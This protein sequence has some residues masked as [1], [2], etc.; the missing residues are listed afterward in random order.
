V[1]GQD[2]GG[3]AEREARAA[4]M[5]A[6]EPAT[7][8][9]LRLVHQAGAVAAL[10]HVL[11]GR[12]A[13][14]AEDVAGGGLD[15]EGMRLRIDS[16]SGRRDLE[17]AAT[18]GARLVIPTDPDWPAGLADLD[19][20]GL[21]CLGLYVRGRGSFVDRVEGA[22]AIVGTRAASD[23]GR[24]VAADLAHG[25]AI[26]GRATVSGLAFGIDAAA[27]QGALS[28]GVEQ[29]GTVAVLACG[30]DMV[31]PK[32]HSWLLS[33]VLDCGLVVSEHPPG[34]APHRAR[35]LIRNR[36][37]AALSTGTVVVEAAARSGARST[38]RYAATLGRAVMAVPGQVTATTSTGCH[39]LLRDDPAVGLIRGVDDI[40]EQ[41]GAIG[42]LAPRATGATSVRDQLDRVATR[43]L[44]A[45]PVS[46]AAPSER[47]AVTAGVSI[48]RTVVVLGQL[49]SAGLVDSATSGWRLGAQERAARATRRGERAGQDA[50]DLDW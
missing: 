12:P 11:S 13:L 10:E 22:V 14:A 19:R 38:A 34:A 24:G 45:V 42:E 49:L 4:L 16:S 1:S 25:L 9:L 7:P 29:A 48:D 32:S 8:G 27:H 18:A 21:G 3:N 37:I 23:Y 6:A 2:E 41:V 31:Y 40:I 43:V 33:R 30:V 44:D 20:G 15:S 39:Q 36:L 28:A 5:R 35:F 50:F 46:R 17:R 47:I 26:R